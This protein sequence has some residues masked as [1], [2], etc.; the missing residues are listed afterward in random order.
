MSPNNNRYY[1]QLMLDIF[2]TALEG[3]INYWAEVIDYRWT[4]RETKKALMKN[5]Y[6]SIKEIDEDN[7]Y[8]INRDVIVRG[9]TIASEELQSEEIRWSTSSPLSKKDILSAS[10][11]DDSDCWDFDAGDADIIVQLGLFKDIQFG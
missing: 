6:A 10:Y 4:D 5:F 8:L 3:G 1:D 7:L 9:Y 11:I 2:T